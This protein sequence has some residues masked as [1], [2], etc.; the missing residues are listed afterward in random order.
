M[1]SE[2]LNPLFFAKDET[3]EN[4]WKMLTR[5]QAEQAKLQ[6]EKSKYLTELYR[7]RAKVEA[8]DVELGELRQNRAIIDR[9]QE[10]KVKLFEDI[11]AFSDD[12]LEQE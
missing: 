7:L 12:K 9:L 8:Q 6:D 5:I 11:S 2:S 3:R 1:N 4:F 10:E